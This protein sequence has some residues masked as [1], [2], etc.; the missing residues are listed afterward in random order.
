MT[1]ESKENNYETWKNQYKANNQMYDKKICDLIKTNLYF[2]Q[3]YNE[4]PI[5]TKI[6]NSIFGGNKE[7]R[8]RSQT[9]ERMENTLTAL[10]QI[11]RSGNPNAENEIRNLLQVMEDKESNI[12]YSIKFAF[13]SL[14]LIP[15]TLLSLTCTFTA[16]TGALSANP[17]LIG[18]GAL[19]AVASAIIGAVIIAKAYELLDLSYKQ[20]ELS[21]QLKNA[22]KEKYPLQN[23]SFTLIDNNML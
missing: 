22:L 16:I 12:S 19:G 7:I 18:L 8:Y 14:A 2:A 23:E 5:A 3:K 13:I 9:Q 20:K 4:R 1:Q 6:R 10:M 17:I 11:L 21:D 15:V